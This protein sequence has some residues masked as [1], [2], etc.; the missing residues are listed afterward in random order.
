MLLRSMYTMIYYIRCNV[1]YR[2]IYNDIQYDMQYDI[3]QRA[4]LLCFHAQV[5]SARS[6]PRRPGSR[7][8]GLLR[9]ISHR[10]LAPDGSALC[11]VPPRRGLR[12][13][14]RGAPHHDAGPRAP[15]GPRAAEPRLAAGRRRLRRCPGASGGASYCGAHRMA[16]ELPKG[17]VV[18]G[19]SKG[20]VRLMCLNTS[21][22]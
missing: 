4:L 12:P 5:I 3:K 11:P 19:W 6:T 17:R 18:S 22:S 20:G 2:M 9:L 14:Q 16:A 21:Y 13:P 15:L 8:P 10:G 1:C 7:P